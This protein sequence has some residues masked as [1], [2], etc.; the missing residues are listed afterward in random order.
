M[1]NDPVREVKVKKEVDK[2]FKVLIFAS[3]FWLIAF[4]F[5]LIEH[6]KSWAMLLPVVGAAI[7]VY[8]GYATWKISLIKNNG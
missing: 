2:H 1:K 5:V 8:A 3:L 4:V 7:I 6:A